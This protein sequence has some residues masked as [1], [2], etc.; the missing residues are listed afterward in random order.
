MIF[1]RSS[2]ILLHPTSLPGQYG[3]GDLGPQAYRWLDFLE[4]TGTKL[5]QILPLG[6]TGY[7]DSPYQSFSA[8]AGNPYLVSPEVL[9]EDGLIT[10]KSMESHPDFST[11]KVDYGALIPWKVDLLQQA[12]RKHKKSGKLAAEFNAYQEDNTDWLPDFALFM[13]MKQAHELRP[14][15]EWPEALRDRQPQAITAFRDANRGGIIEQHAFDQFLFFRQWS[16][17]KEYANE[18]GIKI[19]GDIPIY[20]AHDSSDVWANPELWHLEKDGQPTVVAG[21]PPDY[22]SETGQL[23]GNPIYIWPLHAKEDFAWWKKRIESV[24]Q[25]VDIIR[26]D[27]FRGFAGYWEVAASEE[28]AIN[29]RWL[30]GPGAPIFNA[31]KGHLGSLPLIA[32]DLGV[33]TPDVVALREQFSLPGMKIFQFGLEGGNEDPFV[34][35]NFEENC[36]AYS[37]THDNDTSAGWYQNAIPEH[38]WFARYYLGLDEN[39]EPGLVAWRMIEKLWESV[40]VFTLAPMQDFLGLGTAARMN[41]PG[42]TSGN[43]QW[44]MDEADLSEELAGKLK[45]LN[46]S[47][48]R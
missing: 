10:K 3:I 16:K 32:E 20:V 41:Y 22:F 27:H 6:P 43:W 29:G 35:H 17:L 8:M 33:I 15:V 46:S 25:Q 36:V 38:Q 5:W 45:K 40:G 30:P 18:R 7:A 47:T 44:R 21:V 28:T 12:Y 4:A 39:P 37:G 24:L 19:I 48:N 11:T 9:Y 23:W 26:L 13:A 31:L 42:T 2:G 34:P 1:T 14:W